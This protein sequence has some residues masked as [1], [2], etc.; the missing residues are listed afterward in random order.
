MST[1]LSINSLQQHRT[2]ENYYISSYRIFKNLIIIGFLSVNTV[3]L[4][5]ELNAAELVN[6][7]RDVLSLSIFFSTSLPIIKGPMLLCLAKYKI[8]LSDAIYTLMFE[9]IV[10]DTIIPINDPIN[11]CKSSVPKLGAR[12]EIKNF[13]NLRD[14]KQIS[15]FSSDN[16]Y[17]IKNVIG[18]PN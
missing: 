9:E 6:L 11:M 10:F 4:G 7:F 8:T 2:I 15:L 12:V 3:P 18:S 16:I 14:S 13:N 5:V 1:N 17:L